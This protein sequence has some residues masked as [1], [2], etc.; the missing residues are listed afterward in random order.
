[1]EKLRP[2]ENRATEA[3]Q[4]IS[5]RVRTEIHRG[6]Y[7][8]YPL[9]AI[10]VSPFFSH[11]RRG[12]QAQ[13]T[14]QVRPQSAVLPVQVTHGIQ[15]AMW[16]LET[17]AAGS[18]DLMISYGPRQSDPGQLPALL[19]ASVSP[20]I[21]CE[22]QHWQNPQPPTGVTALVKEGRS[23]S[24]APPTPGAP[25]PLSP[26]KLAKESPTQAQNQWIKDEASAQ[27]QGPNPAGPLNS[28]RGPSAPRARP[29]WPQFAPL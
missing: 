15:E 25:H 17:C 8:L 6:L 23:G 20:S 21:R 14:R 24:P 3:T 7:S 28:L 16:A 9:L 4:Q 2:G 27:K 11:C 13:Q 10:S 12:L 22:L 18:Q 29:S 5:S 1:M 26:K 19:R